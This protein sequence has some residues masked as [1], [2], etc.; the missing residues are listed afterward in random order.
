MRAIFTGKY[1]VTCPECNTSVV[2]A[3]LDAIMWE[4]CPGCGRHTWDRYDTMMAE[5]VRLDTDHRSVT[6]PMIN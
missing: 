5:E 6:G 1:K 2:T 4:P 3:H